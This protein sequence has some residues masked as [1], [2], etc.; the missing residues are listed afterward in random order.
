MIDSSQEE[1][2]IRW[3][4][5]VKKNSKKWKKEHTKFIDAQFLKSKEF[6]ERLSKTKEGR[7]II[8]RLRENR[9]FA[10]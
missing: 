2:V 5:Y 9:T 10:I 8:L 3:A 7:K 1:Q 4:E 6:F